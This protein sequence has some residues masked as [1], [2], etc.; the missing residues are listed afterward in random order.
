MKKPS[1]KKALRALRVRRTHR[2]ELLEPRLT[3]SANASPFPVPSWS[4]LPNGIPILTSFPSSPAVIYL[5]YDGDAAQNISETDLDNTPG[6]FTVYEQNRIYEHWRGI[7]ALYSMFDISVTTVEPPNP[8]LN[9]EWI[10][11]TNDMITK[12]G[13]NGVNSFPDDAPSG[14]SGSDWWAEGYSHEISHGFGN[15][16]Q[17]SYDLLGMKLDEYAPFPSG[18]PLR[19]GIMG[20]GSGTI[21]KWQYGHMS[22][23]VLTIQAD[24]EAI[25]SDVDGLDGAGDGYRPDDQTGTGI[26]S[27]SALSVVDSTTQA[28]IGILERLTDQDWWSFTSTGG[29]YNILVGHDAPSPVDVKISIY[30][31]SGIL[32]ATEDGDPLESAASS[33]AN[34]R[35]MV[36]DTHLT[37]N[38]AAGTY[39]IKVESHGNYSD[40]GQYIA[41]VDRMLDGWRS[42]D[43]GLVYTP[44]FTDFDEAT[45]TFTVGGSGRGI[46][47]TPSQGGDSAQF[48]FTKLIGDGE[49]IAHVD[50]METAKSIIRAGITMRESLATGSKFFSVYTTPSSGVTMQRRSSTNGN[51]SSQ[52]TS[53]F[54]FSPTWIRIKRAGN[55]FTAY[56][57][58]DGVNWTQVGSSQTVVMGSEV[59]VGLISTSAND[60][61]RLTSNFLTTAT[62]TNVQVANQSNIGSVGSAGTSSFDPAT[63]TLTL[64]GRGAGWGNVASQQ[65]ASFVYYRPLAGD[66]SV[67]V[68][69]ASTNHSTNTSG[70]MIRESLTSGSKYFASWIKPN[71]GIVQ[72][73]RSTTSGSSTDSTIPAGANWLRVERTGDIFRAF[74]SVDGNSWTQFGGDELIDMNA[75]VL[76]GLMVASGNTV[77]TN[78]STFD[79]LSF[80]GNV[81]STQ[82]INTLLAPTTLQLSN[83]TP[84]G[85]TLTWVNP[86]VPLAGDYNGDGTVDAADYVVWRATDG[87]PTGYANWRSTYGLSQAI[88]TGFTVQRSSDGVNF[89]TLGTTAAG[90]LSYTDTTATGGEKY[91]YRV[92][93]NDAV[94]VSD[95][96]LAVSATTRAPAVSSLKVYSAD[97]TKLV[98]EWFDASGETDYTLQRSTTG[99][100]SWTTIGASSISKNTPFYVD[101][102]LSAGTQY[103]YRVITV[104][105]SGDSATSATVSAY[106]RLNS[107]PT[108]V[109]FNSASSTSITFSW[110]AIANITR[111]AVYR[112]VGNGSNEWQLLNDNLASPTIT[113]TGLTSGAEYYYRIVGYDANG[114]ATKTA[115]VFGWPGLVTSLPSPWGTQDIG[116]VGTLGTVSYSGGTFTVIGG[117]A[118]IW[119][120]SDEFRYV[121]TNLSGNGFIQA[122]IDSMREPTANYYSRAGLQIRE[123]TAIGSKQVSIMLHETEAGTRLQRR[124]STN[125]GTVE[126]LGP[127]VNS[128]YW[129]RLERSG[130]TFTGKVSPDGVNWTT[131]GTYS[132]S[133][134]TNVLIGMALTPRDDNQVHWAKFDNVTSSVTG[135]GAGSGFDSSLNALAAA[136]LDGITSAGSFS[137]TQLAASSMNNTGSTT[138]S[139]HDTT[140][141]DTAFAHFSPRARFDHTLASDTLSGDHQDAE[142]FGFSEFTTHEEMRSNIFS[143]GRFRKLCSSV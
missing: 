66:G 63:N 80:T 9:T 47:G 21:V 140:L 30:D 115:Q 54:A 64:N 111:Y 93:T 83:L 87:T 52:S 143:Q 131:L 126:T 136:T 57:G 105:A 75:N 120:N 45:G 37:M 28:K 70:V 77:T 34:Y 55:T 35:S 2:F 73:F 49:I 107:T 74:T 19:G 97:T 61:D 40:Q 15:W 27:A 13:V 119:G 60:L 128:P 33:N 110:D 94:G 89:Q 48:A 85:A 16:H 26:G 96:S 102:G 99:T 125:G 29:T 68:H 127:I 4:T 1:R 135:A 104:D 106:T 81:G 62:F 108:N 31:S 39:Y 95:P 24:M 142:E 92:L 10:A 133:M 118:D 124:A 51:S 12:G 7:T 78:T 121:Y 112:G 129:L 41:R 59:L 56:Y 11:I 76:I 103:F 44:G 65:D 67:T 137:S 134:N 114:A 79:N 132:V 116:A 32:L 8:G 88:V 72:S 130:N 138:H 98:I 141:L 58:S 122:R 100:G 43:I 36:N 6:V 14:V 123:T 3:L 18:D 91:Y 23:T 17:S 109:V 86:N 82:P 101:S 69:L 71:T 50:S 84:T 22:D 90:V 42:E 20:A 117:G 113:D 38:L 5:D 25:R 46:G 53:A 139:D